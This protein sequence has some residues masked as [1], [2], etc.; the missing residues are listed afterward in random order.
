[1]K[2]LALIAASATLLTA[3]GGGGL[4]TQ[5]NTGGATNTPVPSAAP[6]AAPVAKSQLWN[7]QLP[8]AGSNVCY[9]IE[10]AAEVACS[11]STWDLK[12]A[13]AA[14]G[15][16]FW[17]NS[18]ESGNGKGGVFGSPFDYS[19]EALQKWQ[20]GLLDP[21]SGQAI[22]DTLYLKDT[23]NSVFAG[24]NGI[25]SAAFE[26]G[27]GGSG[28]HKLYPNFRVFLISSDSTQVS[29]TG[30]AAAPVYALQMIGYYGGPSGTASGY[31]TFRWVDRSVAGAAV[32][33]ASV[34]ASKD[35]VYFNL[36]A[37][38]K[39]AATDTWHIAF[40]RYNVKLNSGS[41]GSGKVGGFAAKTPAGFYAADGKTPI[42]AKFSENNILA[43]TLPELT[44]SD[45]ALPSK[46]SDW[47]KDSIASK[48]NPA[49]VGNYPGKMDYGWYTYYPVAEGS[50][51]AH[52]QVAN[53]NRGVLLR[54]AE[55]NR[56]ARLRLKEIRYATPGDIRSQQTWQFEFEALPASK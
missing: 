47:K 36:S 9:D 4:D 55:G 7:A 26:Y 3:C 28:D 40:N 31:P 6:T 19:W 42:A 45:L 30:S 8:A 50:I 35:W 43:S 21:V 27:V 37:G 44:A 20:A 15:V 51:A 34:D 29:A 2:Q 22:P 32:Q 24:S 12:V 46:A 13:S 33:T 1:M 5:T 25:Q 52:T 48:L 39:V 41:S 11:T 23:A 38:Q 16:S 49:Y 18:G 56:Y 54:T 10:A 53:A 17:S 14:R